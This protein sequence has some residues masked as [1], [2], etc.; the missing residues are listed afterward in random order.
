MANNIYKT[1]FNSGSQLKLP[2]HKN[3]IIY[4]YCYVDQTE[5]WY[6]Y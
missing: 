5:E 4:V 2:I 3:I 6:L 1:L